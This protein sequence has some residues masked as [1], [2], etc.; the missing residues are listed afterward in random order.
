MS[1]AG[2]DEL[3]QLQGA[4]RGVL[5]TAK[6]DAVAEPNDQWRGA[7]GDLAALGVTGLC[8]PEAS[9]G[10]GLRVDA[11]ALTA[12]ELGAALHGGPFAGITAATHLLTVADANDPLAAR[13][14]NGDAVVAWGRLSPDGVTA[15][16]VDG[17]GDVD[18][19]VL[20]D[21]EAHEA[22]VLE[23]RSRWSVI[24]EH[25][26]DVSRRCVDLTLSGSVGRRVPADPVA[27]SVFRLLLAA[28]ALG[29]VEWMLARTVAY[30]GARHAFGRPIGGFQAV[31]HRL[32]DH[33]VRARGMSLAVAESARML[34]SGHADAARFVAMA[35]LS[36]SSNAT[37][38]LHDLLQLTGAI[39]F[40]WEYGLNHYERRVHQDARL[41]GNP[42]T[43]IAA[44]AELEGWS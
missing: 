10:F 22:L 24:A 42:R 37:H 38:L 23:D 2:D 25:D 26:F 34:G 12:A 9:G 36:V 39:G 1:T 33:T 20:H 18:A 7:W 31:Q 16:L 3:R 17:A 13:V 29:C 43:A 14:I 6:D 40:T 28:D 21:V 44:V 19:V 35:E 30:A 41:A 8:A 27:V 4:L 15:R 32:I 5:G 11:A